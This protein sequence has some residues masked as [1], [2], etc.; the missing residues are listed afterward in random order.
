MT[1]PEKLTQHTT[2]FID[3]APII[4]YLAQMP[5]SRMMSD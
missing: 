3:T 5:L 2:V 4:Y 1:L